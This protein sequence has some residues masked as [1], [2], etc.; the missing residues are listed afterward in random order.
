MFPNSLNLSPTPPQCYYPSSNYQNAQMIQVSR[1][2][3]LLESKNGI[4]QIITL[5]DGRI[6]TLSDKKITFWD[7]ISHLMIKSMEI[8]NE[9]IACV[10]Y[11]DY[12]IG[13]S[14]SGKLDFWDLVFEGPAGFMTIGSGCVNVFCK[15]EHELAMGCQ[16]GDIEIWTINGNILKKTGAIR[17]HDLPIFSLCYLPQ[18][19]LFASGS[20]DTTIKLWNPDTFSCIGTLNGHYNSVLFLLEFKGLLISASVDQTIRVWDPEQN[21]R[22]I[23]ILSGHHDS[24]SSLIEFNGLLIS[25]SW[26]KTIKIWD[27][28]QDY[29]SISTLTEHSNWVQS[30]CKL[31]DDLHFVSCSSDK[32]IIF[33][34]KD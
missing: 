6:L 2:E 27:P 15:K 34:K 16:S 22:C 11:D 8:K 30:L 17:A 26:D 18:Q 31:N 14:N 10:E 28:A 21:F 1:K 23:K 32:T 24:I 19:N 3:S 29:R 33:W 20:L 7:P 12:I 5:K 13:C 25:A 9:W 4:Q